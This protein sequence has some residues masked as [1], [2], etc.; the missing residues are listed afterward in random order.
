MK[1][2]SLLLFCSL[3]LSSSAQDFNVEYKAFVLQSFFKERHIQSLT[4]YKAT[5]SLFNNKQTKYKLEFDM[6]GRLVKVFDYYFHSD[7]VPERVITYKYNKD[8]VYYREKEYHYL[9]ERQNVIMRKKWRLQFDFLTNI[10]REE[11]LN[12]TLK[13]RTNNLIFNKAMQ[14]L[15]RNVEAFVV[16][17]RTGFSYSK[18]GLLKQVKIIKEN[19]TVEHMKHLELNHYLQYN[20]YQKIMTTEQWLGERDKQI[21]EFFFSY[22]GQDITAKVG[23]SLVNWSGSD[24][25]RVERTDF[26]YFKNGLLSLADTYTQKRVSSKHHYIGFKY[27]F[28]Y[29]KKPLVKS[30]HRFTALWFTDIFAVNL[31]HP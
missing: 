4:I 31:I 27:A 23:W 9:D 10:L 2:L 5:D 1:F 8:A 6:E 26:H 17:L 11:F 22:K 13:Y 28:F 30:S 15:S 16:K 25:R 18:E 29:G 21:N 3:L 24:K 20:Q 14:L 12:G 7:T 19:P